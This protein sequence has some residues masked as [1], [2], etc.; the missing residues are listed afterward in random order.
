M[1]DI[2]LA[3][4][5]PRRKELMEREGIDFKIDALSIDEVLDDSL[6]L[7][8]RLKELSRSKAYP[9]HLKHP[10]DIVIGA[11][12]IVYH[13][14]KIIGKPVDKED[15][16]RILK[17]LSD[18]HHT[19]YTAVS[20]YNRNE[21]IQFVDH[22]DVYFKDITYMIDD[23]LKSDEWKDKAGAY[24]IQDD[25]SLFV[26]HIEGD[27]DTVIG[28]PVKKLVDVLDSIK[29]GYEFSVL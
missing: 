28:L 10:D 15:A 8:D 22:T 12:T 11:D 18:D 2:I 19:V 21:L 1:A 14:E 29:K 23:Y 7:E 9:V 27:I 3:S 5:S 17:S 13:D 25:A 6:A 20:I 24:A 4:A 26:D 16:Y